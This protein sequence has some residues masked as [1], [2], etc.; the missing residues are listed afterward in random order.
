M[1]KR[2]VFLLAVLAATP[3]V[4]QTRPSF[5]CAKASNSIEKTI[6]ASPELSKLDTDLAAAYA[7]LS[8]RLDAKAKEHLARDENGWIANRAREC[9]AF[10]AAMAFD[11]VKYGYADRVE[12]LKLYGAGPYPFVSTHRLHKAGKVGAVTYGTNIAYPQFDGASADFSAPNRHFADQA[13]KA[14]KENTPDQGS[15]VDRAQEWNYDQDF[16]LYRPT[17]RALTVQWSWQAYSGGAHPNQMAYS[18]LVDLATGK[19]AGLA[20]IFV[21]GALPKI[22]EMVRADLVEQFKK[23]PGDPE[24]LELPKLT[25]MLSDPTHFDFRVGSLS[26]FFNRY[27]IGAYAVG[28]YD[29]D[30]PYARI[31]DLLKPDGPLGALR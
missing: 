11:C 20:D 13:A 1:I 10:T 5:D 4:A 22:V 15:G 31:K 7:A 24:A 8:T 27:D 17:A 21:E 29:V 2:I 23:K 12:R 16:R 26:V 14:L 9:G 18:V 6:C 19:A 30:L 3:A 28:V 25:K